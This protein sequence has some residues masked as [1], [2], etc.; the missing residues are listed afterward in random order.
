MKAKGLIFF[1]V[2]VGILSLS[3][4]FAH[5]QQTVVGTGNYIT[6]VKA[7]QQAVDQGGTVY[8]KG[9]FF[10]GGNGSI[11]IKKDVQIIGEKEKDFKTRITGGC[12]V[13]KTVIPDP[14]SP[15]IPGPKITIQNIHFQWALRNAIDLPY[16]SGATIIGNKFS[17]F[18]IY[19]Y[20]VFKKFG[21]LIHGITFGTFDVYSPFP[22]KKYVP[23]AF[24]GKLVIKD[25]EMDLTIPKPEETLGIGIMISWTTGVSADISGNKF[26]NSP[27]ESIL[28]MDN[29]KDKDGKGDFVISGNQIVTNSTG[30]DEPDDFRPTGINLNVVDHRDV[31]LDEY[32]KYRVDNNFIKGQGEKARGIVVLVNDAVIQNNHVIV[33]EADARGI[34]ILGSRCQV[35]NNKIEGKGMCGILIRERKDLHK[36]LLGYGNRL[37]GNDFTK[38]NS[39]NGDVFIDKRASKNVVIGESG[40]FNDQGSDNQIKGLKKGSQ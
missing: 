26:T 1:M 32:V 4:S 17:A 7:V 31:R 16:S 29:F 18:R 14:Y 36:D 35:L 40:T 13:F 8:L 25:N 22:Q 10:F 39:K 20:Q 12:E 34:T 19:R 24:T 2:S 30:I 3:F 27:R 37:E 9:N 15:D 38:F 33:G 23:G 21:Y 28:L 11:I 5:A 6:D